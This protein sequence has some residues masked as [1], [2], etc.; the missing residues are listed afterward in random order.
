VTGIPGAVA[1]VPVGVY[2]GAVPDIT[3]IQDYE[4]F[5]GMPAGTTVDFVL[6]FMADD[7]SWPQFGAAILQ[8]RT[9]GPAGSHS[10]AEWAPLLDS[11]RLVL[12]VP[13][14]CQGSS[15]ADEAA[16]VND[17]HWAA[18][19]YMLVNGGLGSCVLRI[20]REFTGSWYP[21]TVNPGN[22]AAF[23]AGYARIVSTMRDAGFTGQFMWNPYLGQGTMGPNLGAENCWPGDSVVDVIGIDFYDGG[24][25]AGEMVRTADQQ[26]AAW[27]K[28]RDQWDG[29]SGWVHFAKDLKHKPLAYP[30]WGLRLWN[31]NG[32]YMGGG[33]NALLVT[34]MAAWMKNTGQNGKT[35]M[36][37]FW[38]DS[39]M[40]VSDPDGYPGRLVAVRAARA[41][42]TSLF[43]WT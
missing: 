13:A 22:A 11:R 29:L 28:L 32:K 16:G 19:A 33:D 38:E 35:F 39:G 6:A 37:A 2:R 24:Y 36:H 15:W 21:W 5:L 17:V 23:Q 12:A 34:E 8:S 25:P 14:C 1:N 18:L 40:G 31:D 41:E 30:E 9:N 10:A 27:A 42:F 3:R 26:R 4:A 43:G 7:P 20:A